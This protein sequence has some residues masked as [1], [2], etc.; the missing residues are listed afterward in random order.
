MKQKVK[1]FQVI[2][3]AFDSNGNLIPK[4]KRTTKVTC[5]GTV[6]TPNREVSYIKERIWNLFNWTCWWRSDRKGSYI[7]AIRKGF[8]DYGFRFFPNSNARG[9]CNGDIFFKLNNK[10]HIALSV[11]WDEA[12]S[13][14]E[15]LKICIEN[16][17]W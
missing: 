12:D 3:G 14:E 16:Q 9:Y 1:V 8:R 15:A 17:R 11:G 4:E 7:Q 10:W 2:R 13:Y 5:I 6:I